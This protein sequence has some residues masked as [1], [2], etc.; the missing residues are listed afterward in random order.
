MRVLAVAA[1]LL[2]MN[3]GL[4]GA[5]D[6]TVDVIGNDGSTIG[7]IA[8]TQGPHG[9][10]L[11]AEFQ[12][13]AL[14]PGW[15]GIHVH[16][17]GDCSDHAEFQHSGGHVNPGGT[18]HGFLNPAGPHPS[19]LPNIFAHADGSSH[20]EILVVGVSLS[21]GEVE[22]LDADGSAVVVHANPDDHLTQPIGGAG[23]RV[24]CAVL[25]Q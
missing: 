6:L 25:V 11:R 3:S 16:A 22:L 17:V 2:G 15:H 13:G 19:D 8:A 7:S 10:V 20:A 9:V 12:E 21:G 5:Q 24:G 1:V 4:A 14:A 23:P 18:E